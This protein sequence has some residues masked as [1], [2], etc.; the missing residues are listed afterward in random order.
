MELVGEEQI[1]GFLDACDKMINS[2]FILIDKRVADVLKSIAENRAVYNLIAECMANFDFDKEFKQATSTYNFI[3]PDDPKKLVAFVFCLFNC[4]DDKKIN[5]NDLLMKYYSK[6]KD[7]SP[8]TLFNENVTTKFKNAAYFLLVGERIK[9][10]VKKQEP[11]PQVVNDELNNRLIFLVSDLKDYVDGL[12]KIKGSYV[13][14]SEMLEIIITLVDVIKNNQTELYKPM[15]I[16]IKASAGKDK[17]LQKRVKAIDEILI[18]Q[19]V[20]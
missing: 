9:E 5:I 13:T 10:E 19:L 11:E 17:E 3:L 12:K 15:L 8:Y 14:R 2:K 4:L 1:K 20:D 16:S 7:T 6:D 18:N